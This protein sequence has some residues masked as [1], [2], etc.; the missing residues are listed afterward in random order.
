MSDLDL[1]FSKFEMSDEVRAEVTAAYDIN[2]AGLK[3][4]ISGFIDSGKEMK[5]ELEKVQLDFA[6]AAQDAKI[7]KAESGDN[8]EAYKAALAEKDA[9]IESTNLAFAA[10]DNARITDMAV[11]EFLSDNICVDPAK[12]MYMEKVYRDRIDVVDG[13]ISSKDVTKDMA[14]LKDSIIK[15]DAYKNYIKVEVGSGAGSAGSTTTHGQAKSLSQMTATEE[16]AFAN[17][18]PEQYAQMTK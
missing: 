3:S 18:Q 4:K 10:K 14:A 13:A 16:A 2:V 17:S 7:A 1:D 15:N 5:D 9:L 6:T 8:V 12:K 11:N